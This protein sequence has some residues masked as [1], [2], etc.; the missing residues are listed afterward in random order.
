MKQLRDWQSVAVLAASLLVVSACGLQDTTSPLSPA[1]GDVTASTMHIPFVPEPEMVEV[2]KV[3][4]GGTGPAVQFNYTVD[5]FADGSIDVTGSV[6]VQPGSCVDVAIGGTLTHEHEVVVTE[7]V[8]AGFASAY[9]TSEYNEGAI[10]TLPEA[11][12]PSATGYMHGD[13]GFTFVFNNR[14]TY[15]CSH[16]YWKAPQHADA[17]PAGYTP[18]TLFDVVFEN[19]FPGMTL[20]EVLSLPGGGLNA[21][22]REAVAAFL[23]AGSGFFWYGPGEVQTMFNDV[24]PGTKDEYN[25]VKDLFEYRNVAGCPLN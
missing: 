17:W 6:V 5:D 1:I 21:L 4:P 10:T 14:G 20:D 2:C 11:V 15:G 16:G 25:T 8:P 19:A 3:Y 23:N 13:R 22:G 18:S 7:V 9:S 24:F 12:G